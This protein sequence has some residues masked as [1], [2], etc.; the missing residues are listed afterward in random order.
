MDDAR[1]LICQ[2]K[3]IRR[4]HARGDTAQLGVMIADGENHRDADAVEK[5]LEQLQQ[6]YTDSR[7][8]V[9]HIARHHQTVGFVFF[10]ESR[11]IL[12]IP[13][14]VAIRHRNAPRTECRRLAQVHIRHHQRL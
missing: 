14:I 6:L 9:K 13:G 8:C 1:A 7:G 3:V 5:P 2:I 11:E 10:H 12:K 4:D